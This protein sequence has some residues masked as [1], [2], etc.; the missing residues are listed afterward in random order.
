MSCWRDTLRA[1]ASEWHVILDQSGNNL[2]T[3]PVVAVRIASA[4]R[5]FVFGKVEC[6]YLTASSITAAWDPQPPNRSIFYPAT[7]WFGLVRY[8][9]EDY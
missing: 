9:R 1:L 3:A 8:P 2:F 4:G 7:P 6:G 5:A